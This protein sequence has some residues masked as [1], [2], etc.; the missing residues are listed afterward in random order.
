MTQPE[1]T[2]ARFTDTSRSLIRYHIGDAEGTK[3]EHCTYDP[4]NSQCKEILKKFG[5]ETLEKNYVDFN[6][7]ESTTFNYFN[8]FTE[9]IDEI[10]AIIDKRWHDLPAHSEILDGIQIEEKE[11]VNVGIKAIT[12]IHNDQEHFFKLK[13]EIFELDE[14][15]SSSDRAWKARMRKATTSLELLATLYEVYSKADSEEAESQ[16]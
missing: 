9:N 11:I 2:Y 5:L 7:A 12:D 14:V 16:D 13:L 8:I 3:I 1:I 15:K 10:T 4:N 6:K